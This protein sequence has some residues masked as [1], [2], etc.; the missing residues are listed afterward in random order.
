M[1]TLGGGSPT[2]VDAIVDAHCMVPRTSLAIAVGTAPAL[3][4]DQQRNPFREAMTMSKAPRKLTLT[5]ETL[6]PLQNNELTAING[7]T[8]PSPATPAISAVSRVSFMASIRAC[9]Q[10]SA[11]TVQQAAAS[12]G[13]VKAA[14]QTAK[15]VTHAFLQPGHQTPFEIA[16]FGPG[17]TGK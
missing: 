7:G 13:G 4:V 9:Y 17:V 14:V 8:S 2:R 15:K 12:F 1:S 6:L 3:M 10:V 16:R 5:R 11:V